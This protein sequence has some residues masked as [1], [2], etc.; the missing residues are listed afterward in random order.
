M[1]ENLSNHLYRIKKTLCEMLHD[2][3]YNVSR[4]ELEMSKEDFDILYPNITRKDLDF[5]LYKKKDTQDQICVFITEG[6]GATKKL[7]TAKIKEIAKRMKSVNASRSI[8]VYESGTTPVIKQGIANLQAI[9]IFIELFKEDELLVNITKHV[10]VP[11]HV[12]LSDHEKDILLKRYNLTENQL[13]RMQVNDP[14][15]RYYGVQKGQVFKIIRPSETAGRYVT[16][17]YVL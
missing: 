5:T 8:V 3:G 17:R 16:Y 1:G 14:I 10:L 15:A 12:V 9:K 11:Q 2:R 6:E 7:G 13:P 4:S